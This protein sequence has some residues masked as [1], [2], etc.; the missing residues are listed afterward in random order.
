M[1]VPVEELA[2]E[3]VPAFADL[4]A[5]V[6]VGVLSVVAGARFGLT[7]CALRGNAGLDVTSTPRVAGES[8]Q[9]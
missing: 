5:M 8:M 4:L 1:L 6:A 3:L 9:P 7:P 2:A